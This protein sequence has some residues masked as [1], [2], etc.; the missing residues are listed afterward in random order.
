MITS[1]CEGYTLAD[2]QEVHPVRCVSEQ[3]RSSDGWATKDECD[4]WWENDVNGDCEELT[5]DNAEQFCADANARLPT[6]Q[7][8][9]NNCVQGSGCQFDHVMI[10]TSTPP[11]NKKK[12][13]NFY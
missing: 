4:Y 12:R 8:T 10:W 9:E 5:Y 7:E 6:M 11:C 13:E 3:D 1:Q 2:D